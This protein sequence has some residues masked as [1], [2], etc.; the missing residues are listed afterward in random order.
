MKPD[1]NFYRVTLAQ[2]QEWETAFAQLDQTAYTEEA[3][4]GLEKHQGINQYFQKVMRLE[5]WRLKRESGATE[6]NES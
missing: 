2:L 6:N 1:A 5:L 3:H 4:K